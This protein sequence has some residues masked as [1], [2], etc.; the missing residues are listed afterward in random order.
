MNRRSFLG[1][2]LAPLAVRFGPTTQ[3][4][5]SWLMLNTQYWGVKHVFDWKTLLST[6]I[7]VDRRNPLLP[8]LLNNARIQR[9]QMEAFFSK[10]FF[11]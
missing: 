8:L 2:L 9:E 10:D 5:G 7:V 3:A 4:K 6:R 1:L 11:A